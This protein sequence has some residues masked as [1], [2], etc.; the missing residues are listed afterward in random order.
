MAKIRIPLRTA[1]AQRALELA[2]AHLARNKTKA[3]CLR[4]REFIFN[5]KKEG[6]Q[7]VVL[8]TATAFVKPQRKNIQVR[9]KITFRSDDEDC[10]NQMLDIMVWLLLDLPEG[11]AVRERYWYIP[12]EDE[13]KLCDETADDNPPEKI[14][15]K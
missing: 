7:Q 15:F 10:A 14:K 6:P 1:L 13:L 8:C 3:I 4:E 2:C 9:A 12:W 5:A 11:L